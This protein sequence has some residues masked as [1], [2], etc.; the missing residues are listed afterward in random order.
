[1]LFSFLFPFLWGVEIL[2][3]LS[4]IYFDCFNYFC[5][6][7]EMVTAFEG[8]PTLRMSKGN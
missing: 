4:Y 2:C 3:F 8:I 7:F 6:A 1:M 5:D